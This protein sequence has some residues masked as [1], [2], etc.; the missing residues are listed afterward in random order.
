M[1]FRHKTV[2][3]VTGAGR[4]VERGCQHP[5]SRPAAGRGSG[6]RAIWGHGGPA[7]SDLVDRHG[8]VE[9]GPAEIGTHGADREPAA[10]ARSRRPPPVGGRRRVRERRRGGSG[11]ASRR[12]RATCPAVAVPRPRRR[13]PAQRRVELPP[14]QLALGG[15]EVLPQLEQAE[16]QAPGP[17]PLLLD[18][19]RAQL[20]LEPGLVG[21]GEVGGS[22]STWRRFSGRE[23]AA[24]GEGAVGPGLG[25]VELAAPGQR[26]HER[27][28]PAALGAE[29]EGR[30]GVGQVE[31]E[32]VG[33]GVEAGG[34]AAEQPGGGRAEDAQPERSRR[35]WTGDRG[36]GRR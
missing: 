30:G 36:R 7:A 1:I 19:R 31:V 17:P 35:R 21:G 10:T 8:P 25:Q 3:P 11:V 24:H 23:L 18:R 33:R 5:R 27:R 34:Q 12:R 26:P 15:L 32:A 22:R 13:L 2:E 14:Q 28:V 6:R 29:A 20:A 4:C 9:I 16:R